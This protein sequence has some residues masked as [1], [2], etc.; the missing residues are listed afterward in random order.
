MLHK[1]S[2]TFLTSAQWWKKNGG[3]HDE[4]KVIYPG[5]AEKNIF[6][7]FSS[8]SKW[9]LSKWK[10]KVMCRFSSVLFGVGDARKEKKDRAIERI[11][12]K[13][14]K[15]LSP[16]I[17]FLFFNLE[18]CWGQRFGCTWARVTVKP[19]LWNHRFNGPNIYSPGSQRFLPEPGSKYS[20]TA[21]NGRLQ[22]QTDNKQKNS[23]DK[24]KKKIGLS[25]KNLPGVNYK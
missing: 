5:S 22:L 8:F 13:G 16:W 10:W 4:S 19:L 1:L 9:S 14:R 20:V 7:P 12:A 15:E 11:R 18:Y 2:N 17:K 6:F 3:G 23:N 24:K 21:W 25:Q